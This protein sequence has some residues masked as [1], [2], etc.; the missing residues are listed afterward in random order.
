VRPWYI[1]CAPSFQVGEASSNLAGR[2]VQCPF[3]LVEDFL[4]CKQVAMVRFHQ[5]AFQINNQPCNNRLLLVGLAVASMI[6]SNWC[7]AQM[8]TGTIL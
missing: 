6:W 5:G 4:S 8:V 3:R 2:L 1:G 7:P